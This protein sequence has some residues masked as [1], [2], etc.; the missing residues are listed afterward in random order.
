MIIGV[1]REIKNNEHRVALT[2]AGVQTLKKEGHRV[3]VETTA[4]LGSG[5][6][7]AEYTSMGAQIVETAKLVFRE[8]EMILKVKEPLLPEFELLREH[9]IL[10]TYLHLAREEEL[11][12]VLLRKRVT[13]IAYETIQLDDGRL[14]LLIPM[15][16]IAGKMSTQIG[17]H[18]LEE[19]QGGRG[20]LL[21]G[22]PGVPPAKVVVI[23]AGASGACAAKVAIGMGA[24][25]TLIDLNIDRLRHFDDLYDGRVRTM[26]SNPYNIAQSV[27]K[28]DLLIGAVL[29]PGAKAP[30]L[31][32]EDMVK[33]MRPGSVIVDIAIDQGGCIATIDR[34]STHSHPVY[35]KYGVIHYSVGNIPGAVPF[36]STSALT[37]VTLPYVLEIAGRGYRIAAMKNQ[38]LAKG[39]N[40]C[41]GSVT[42]EAVALSLNLP[43][44]P[45]E[46]VLK[47]KI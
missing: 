30:I 25:V 15:S 13:A 9:Q 1:P 35:I 40:T 6:N 22:V 12:G 20:I 2:P 43:Y 42:Y 5:F 45:L 37:N 26:V 17:A 16:E 27:E 33:K 46:E 23:G 39:F 34:V 10:F 4:G 7:D 44:Q 47:L 18:F 29:V 38:A 41:Q 11:T 3:L 19:P 28:A 14:P 8:A 24:E 36:T 32:T 31:V 21:G